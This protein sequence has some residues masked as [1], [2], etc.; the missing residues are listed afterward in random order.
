MITGKEFCKNC[1]RIFH[2]LYGEAQGLF[3]PVRILGK[4]AMAEL[5][6]HGLSV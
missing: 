2:F 5:L 3:M 6:V 1:M 4:D